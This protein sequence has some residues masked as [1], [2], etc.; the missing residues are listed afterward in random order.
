MA[1]TAL[2]TLSLHDALPIS[3]SL[4]PEGPDQVV[5][6]RAREVEAARGVDHVPALRLEG[7]VQEAD[8]EAA[9]RLLEG[10]CPLRLGRSEEHT[11][12]LQSHS[13]LVCRLLLEKKK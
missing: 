2:Y 11:S 12:E 13:E 8:L 3:P 4:Q 9:G 5:D 6:V 7:V 1:P 10:G